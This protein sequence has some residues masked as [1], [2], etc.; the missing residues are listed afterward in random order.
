MSAIGKQA[1][2]GVLTLATC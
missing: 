1:H 2:E